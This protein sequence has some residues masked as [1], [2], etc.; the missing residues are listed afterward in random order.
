MLDIA[1]H[2]LVPAEPL[3]MDTPNLPVPG[4]KADFTKQKCIFSGPL[5]AAFQSILPLWRETSRPNIRMP[6]AMSLDSQSS[7][8]A[9][10]HTLVLSHYTI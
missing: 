4:D 10:I 3:A 5:T 8:Y 6:V 9:I 2:T 7:K 1:P